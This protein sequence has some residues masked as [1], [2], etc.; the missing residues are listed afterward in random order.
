MIRNLVSRLVNASVWRVCANKSVPELL[1]QLQPLCLPLLGGL[2]GMS[3]KSSFS[4][5]SG[6]CASW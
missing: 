5:E 2:V 6:A 4:W 1:G 3:R